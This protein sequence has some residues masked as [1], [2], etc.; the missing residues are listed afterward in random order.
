M[1]VP[2]RYWLLTFAADA[3][4]TLLD[5]CTFGDLLRLRAPDEPSRS[6][7][8]RLCTL[9]SSVTFI[10]KSKFEVIT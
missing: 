5:C 1:H 10:D 8:E 6:T 3:L 9:L 7:F 2:D 4:H